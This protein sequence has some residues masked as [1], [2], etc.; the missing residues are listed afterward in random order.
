MLHKEAVQDS[1]LDLLI[2][3]QGLPAFQ[4]LRLVGDTSLALQIGHR[5]SIDIDLFGNLAI[6]LIELMV[7]LKPMGKIELV[8][9]S[10][11]IHFYQ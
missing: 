5:Q 10:K 4:F 2:K 7:L 11:A 6:D 8:G 9:G 1:L 3:L